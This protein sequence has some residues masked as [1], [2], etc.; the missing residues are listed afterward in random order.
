MNPD[1]VFINA[2][3]VLCN[4]GKDTAE[5]ASNLQRPPGEL[6]ASAAYGSDLPIP[7]GAWQGALPDIPFSEKSGRHATTGSPSRHCIK[8]NRNWHRQ[9]SNTAAN[10]SGL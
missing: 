5:I 2:L 8:S 9:G 7:V 10:A 1:D 3:G 4:S 6:V